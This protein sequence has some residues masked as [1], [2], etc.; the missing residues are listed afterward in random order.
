LLI[1]TI[2]R[3]T[4]EDQASWAPRI[5]ELEDEVA[6]ES[7]AVRQQMP[8]RIVRYGKSEDE[9]LDIFAPPGVRDAQVIV[10]FAEEKGVENDSTMRK[11]ELMFAVLKQLD[12][13]AD[14]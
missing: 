12:R 6:S 7:A 14:R 2:N 5:K 10:S 9:V 1:A 13:A 4:G 11:Q 8:P 3:S